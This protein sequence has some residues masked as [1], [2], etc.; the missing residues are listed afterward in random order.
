MCDSSNCESL[1]D[2]VN[3]LQNEM[4]S[5]WFMAYSLMST[6]PAAPKAKALR[7]K[8]QCKLQ[9]SATAREWWRFREAPLR[10]RDAQ[11][12]LS[13]RHIWHWLFLR[14]VRHAGCVVHQHLCANGVRGTVLAKPVAMLQ[15]QNRKARHRSETEGLLK[16]RNAELNLRLISSMDINGTKLHSMMQHG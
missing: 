5:L 8:T 11:E 1:C 13:S 4:H 2:D 3:L 16:S 12:I 9:L 14:S 10:Y 15:R 7:Q 6:S